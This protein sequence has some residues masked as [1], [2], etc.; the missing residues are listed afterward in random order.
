VPKLAVHKL[1]KKNSIIAK[2]LTSFK[3]LD[4]DSSLSISLKDIVLFS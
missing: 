3:N 4:I 2:E 1:E